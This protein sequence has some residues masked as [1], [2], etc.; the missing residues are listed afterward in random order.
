MK[1]STSRWYVKLEN[2]GQAETCFLGNYDVHLETAQ[3]IFAK[4]KDA[5]KEN[6][7]DTSLASDGASVMM[8]AHAGVGALLKKESP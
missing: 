4:V 5:L 3:C 6:G 7:I 2:E 1:K 8:G